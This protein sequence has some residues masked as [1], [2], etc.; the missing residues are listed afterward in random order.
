MIVMHGGCI[1]SVL[2]SLL[3][4]KGRMRPL[5]GA[6][7]TSLTTLVGASPERHLGA[8]KTYNDTLHLGPENDEAVLGEDGKAHLISLLGLAADVPL[9]TPPP[10]ARTTLDVAS[11]RL[12]TYA[13]GA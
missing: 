7:N 5:E 1:R 3:Q 11:R 6:R 8:L 9:L 13:I 4:L 12:V 2:F 10:R